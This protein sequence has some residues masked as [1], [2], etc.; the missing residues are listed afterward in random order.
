MTTAFNEFMRQSK[1]TGREKADGYSQD[2]FIG[3]DEYEKETVFD[4]L[5]TE[6]PFSAEWLFPLDTKKAIAIVKEKEKEFR[7]SPYKHVYMLQENLVKYS[8]DLTYQEH[9]IEDYTNYADRL[10]PLVVESISRT[11]TN[12]TT[13]NFF[14]QIV[15]VE[16]NTNA[17]ARAADNLLY[18]LKFP[19]STTAEKQKYDRLIAELRS[20]NNEVKKR[21]LGEIEKKETSFFSTR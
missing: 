4:L 7:G 2:A 19:R 11:P 6:L 15:L 20:D 1:M 9:M 16:T 5:V 14:K 17:V 13:I 10:K 3:L 8:G 18:L 21:A 12:E